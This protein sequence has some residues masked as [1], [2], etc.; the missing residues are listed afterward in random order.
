[1]WVERER[2]MNSRKRRIA[3]ARQRP[4]SPL[5]RFTTTTTYKT[6]SLFFKGD[7]SSASE[8]DNSEDD[9]DS[10]DLAAY[11]CRHC[12]STCIILIFNFN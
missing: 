4:S 12:F 6:F 8:D 10:R 11:H 7:L 3:A 5:G 9:S 1:M 2:M